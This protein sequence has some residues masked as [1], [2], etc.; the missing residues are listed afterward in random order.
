MAI[1]LS[2]NALLRGAHD[3]GVIKSWGPGVFVLVSF[4][5]LLEAVLL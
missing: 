2:V 4:G 1:D 3:T 5:R